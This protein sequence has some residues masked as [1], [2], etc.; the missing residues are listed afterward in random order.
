MK[1]KGSF[2]GVFFNLGLFQFLTFVR[3]GVFYS[4][5]INYLFLLMGNVTSTA[6][7]GTLN[8][9]AS[10]L[11]QNL[12][13][14]KVSDRYKLRAKLIIAGE[15]IAG[16]AYILVFFVHKSLIDMG[17]SFNAGLSII[18]G[19]SI[20]E[21]FW[22]MSDVGWAAL[23]T[24]ITTPNVRGKIVGILNFISSFGRM[25]GIIFAGVL[26]AGGEGFRQ[27]TIFFIVTVMLFVGAFIMWVVSKSTK[28][29]SKIA[30]ESR[31]EK[32]EFSVG[33]KIVGDNRKV[34]RWFLLS[35][36]IIILGAS[37][38]NQVFLLF[39]TLPEGLNAT[40]LKMSF[41]LT[42]WTVGGMVASVFS[43][44]LADKIGRTKVILYGVLLAIATP[45]LYGFVPNYLL[46][47]L[48]YGLNGV[49]FWTIQTVGFALAGDLIASNERGRLLSR[50]NAVMALSWGPA[51]LLV[52]G[53]LAD[54]QISLGVSPHSAYVN[55]FLFS[56][57]LVAVGAVIFF[58][59]VKYEA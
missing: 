11:G 14:G 4:F 12:L 51:G 29:S 16:F 37:S 10:T 7:L 1:L 5:M 49:S 13:W 59:K 8:M 28:E 55:V 32:E 31:N 45:L 18:F 15:S 24:D 26:Y 50:Y 56:S 2:K 57:F 36:T 6:S 33:Q 21:F 47:A 27:G 43:G 17:Y 23:L 3:R 34:Y 9:V 44:R 30:F 46:M 40:D 20:L 38:L 22:S 25:I 41:I 42:A 35:L 54:T 53:P 39:I 19:L 52:G 58:L 48:V